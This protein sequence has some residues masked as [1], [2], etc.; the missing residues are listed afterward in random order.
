MQWTQTDLDHAI[1]SHLRHTDGD[2]EDIR[3]LLQLEQVC[4]IAGRAGIDPIRAESAIATLD[5]G[6]SRALA[7]QARAVND[8]LVDGQSRRFRPRPPLLASCC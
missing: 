3:R 6:E 5:S 7:T 1:T 8:S 2:R 4:E